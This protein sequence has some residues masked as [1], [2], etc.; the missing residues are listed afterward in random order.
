MTPVH[1][2]LSGS[3]SPVNRPCVPSKNN[4]GKK[5]KSHVISDA[6]A[7]YYNNADHSDTTSCLLNTLLCAR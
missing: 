2:V 3:T 6:S 4:G 1:T 7:E 5:K